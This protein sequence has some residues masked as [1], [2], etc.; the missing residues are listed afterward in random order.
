M[1]LVDNR[2]SSCE[3]VAK[4]VYLGGGNARMVLTA[5]LVRGRRWL[6]PGEAGTFWEQMR[7]PDVIRID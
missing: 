5:W 4:P 7:F 2:P 6:A 3:P 1:A